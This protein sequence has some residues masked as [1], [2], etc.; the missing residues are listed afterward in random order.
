MNEDRM[1]A[2]VFIVWTVLLASFCWMIWYGV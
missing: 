1:V 2:A